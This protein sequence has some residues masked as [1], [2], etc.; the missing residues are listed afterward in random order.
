MIL[1]IFNAFKSCGLLWSLIDLLQILNKNGEKGSC[2]ESGVRRA[3]CPK[4]K[5]RTSTA[6]F[7]ACPQGSGK[8]GRDASGMGL[9][10]W[11]IGRLALLPGTRDATTLRISSMETELAR[12]CEVTECSDLGQDPAMGLGLTKGLRKMEPSGADWHFPGAEPTVRAWRH[13]REAAAA[14][15]A[16]DGDDLPGA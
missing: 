16:V 10:A 14:L 5:G 11:Y 2:R 8:P 6:C 9:R 12:G 7:F 15:L 3:A 4:G 1:T 13:F